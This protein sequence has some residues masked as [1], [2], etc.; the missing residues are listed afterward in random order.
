MNENS[1]DQTNDNKT[2]P[3]NDQEAKFGVL[4]F[5]LGVIVGVML[6]IG[7]LK[8]QELYYS[9]KQTNNIVVGNGYSSS[10]SNNGTVIINGVNMGADANIKGVG[11]D[12]ND[13]AFSVVNNVL[14]DNQNNIVITSDSQGRGK[15]IINNSSGVI[16]VNGHVV[17]GCKKNVIKRDSSVTTVSNYDCNDE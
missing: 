4:E 13:G 7:I 11:T 12:A 6:S 10:T 2:A 5:M 15:T 1:I 8:I 16:T 17:K 14:G 3:V 9:F